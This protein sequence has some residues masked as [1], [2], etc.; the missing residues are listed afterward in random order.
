[1]R[2]SG[3][4]PSSVILSQNS[5]YRTVW[6]KNE[7]LYYKKRGVFVT[8]SLLLRSVHANLIDFCKHVYKAFYCHLWYACGDTIS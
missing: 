6:V 8:I 1:M 2:I 5:S 7:T 4:E 3:T